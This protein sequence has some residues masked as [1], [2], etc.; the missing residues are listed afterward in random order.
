[1]LRQVASGFQVAGFV[2]GIPSLLAVL[3]FGGS[4]ITL[5][6]MTPPDSPTGHA[7]PSLVN[8]LVDGARLLGKIFGFIGAVGQTLFTIIACVA[9]VVLLFAVL[10]FFTGRG[11]IDN[12]TW[13]RVVAMGISGVTFLIAALGI[14]STRRV[15][16]LIFFG[17]FA[18]ASGYALWALI[19]R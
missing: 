10:C 4:A 14:L 11:L 13:A 12:A 15:P 8:Y 9:L 1:M 16:G 6:M 19:K 5:R 18:A 17:P 2:L 3:F 7:G